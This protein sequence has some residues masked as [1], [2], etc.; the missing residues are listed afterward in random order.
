MLE[1]RLLE[2]EQAY[3]LQNDNINMKFVQIPYSSI[4]DS[5][6]EVTKSEIKSYLEDH[7]SRF[8]TEAS[9]NIQY[10][11]FNE[12]ASSEDKSEAKKTIS[13]LRNERVEYNAAIGANDTVPDLT[14]Q[15]IM[16]ISSAIIL[17][18]LSR[19]GLNS[20]MILPEI[21][22][23]PSSI[24]TKVKLMVLMRRMDTGN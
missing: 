22:L 20:E 24:L 11:I 15:M 16:P 5:E 1:Q 10:V 12:S 6:V 14:I 21:M 18:F 7:K 23:K 3:R 4:P 2:G 17:I 19:T 13:S 8:E 9:R